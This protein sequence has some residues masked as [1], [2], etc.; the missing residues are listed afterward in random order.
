MLL[1]AVPLS[2]YELARYLRRTMSSV[3]SDLWSA[4]RANRLEGFKFRRKAV[5]GPHIVDFACLSSRLVVEIGGEMYDRSPPSDAARAAWLETCGFRIIDSHLTTSAS[6][7]SM[8]C[9]RSV[10]SWRPARQLALGAGQDLL[11]GGDFGSVVQRGE[12]RDATAPERAPDQVVG[13]MRVLG[14]QR[15]V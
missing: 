12:V 10:A 8:C 4:L 5:I 14:Q 13:E 2:R 7:W 11:V 6:V 1:G 15:A 3:E 9:R